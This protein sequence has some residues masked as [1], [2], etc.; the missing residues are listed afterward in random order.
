MKPISEGLAR[1]I[2]AICKIVT[3]I[4][5]TAGVVVGLIK[6]SGDRDKE[7]AAREIEIR[8]PLLEK[9][10]ELCLRIASDASTIASSNDPSKKEVA[11]EDFD[12]LFY[13]PFAV[14]EDMTIARGAVPF[15]LC[16]TNS[17]ECTQ[18]MKALARNLATA[19]RDSLEADWNAPHAP[20]AL[21]GGIQVGR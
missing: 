8:K 1:T 9:R 7:I 4:V 11:Q 14:I 21:S 3:A 20:T 18:P 2:D 6:Y 10:L 12:N 13:G 5:L 15:F 17:K 19:C 16:L